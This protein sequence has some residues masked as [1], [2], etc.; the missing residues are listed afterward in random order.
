MFP[1]GNQAEH[2]SLY[3]DGSNHDAAGPGAAQGWMRA[4]K[5]SLSVVNQLDGAN[6][7]IR[8]AAPALSPPP[9]TRHAGADARGLTRTARSPF[10]SP[11]PETEHIFHA[12]EIDWGFREFIHLDTVYDLSKGFIVNDKIIVEVE[13]EVT[14]PKDLRPPQA[15]SSA[16]LALDG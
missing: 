9:H 1:A 8:G 7:C 16:P 5:F 11:P 15:G 4:A 12:H 2:L 6:S 13:V 10:P 3:L 14:R